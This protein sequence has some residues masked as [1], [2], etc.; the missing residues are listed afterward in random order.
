MYLLQNEI[1]AYTLDDQGSVCSVFH[2][3]TGHEYCTAKGELF[4]L[5]YKF[6]DFEER[7]IDAKDQPA[8]KIAVNGNVMT[9]T[10]E[11]LVSPNGVLEIRLQ[12]TL[13]L[14]DERL[15]VVSEI[16]NNSEVEVMELITTALAGIG[17]LGDKTLTD[18]LVTPLH[19]GDDIKDPYHAD[20]FKHSDKLYKRKYDRPDHRH[21][22]LDLPYPGMCC[23]QIM[24]CL[25]SWLPT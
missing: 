2:K 15:T 18:H 23:M 22:D 1:V 13:T 20:F 24:R 19:L 11:N 17:T 9:V 12:F 3:K 21:A 5:L 8:P 10:Y 7:P 25:V 14:T 6:E 4:R 16:E